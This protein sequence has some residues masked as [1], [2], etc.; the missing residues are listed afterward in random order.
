MF[1]PVCANFWHVSC[2]LMQNW[3]LLQGRS[4]KVVYQYCALVNVFVR[5]SMCLIWV[6]W[7]YS[8]F[9][10][11]KK[12]D[13]V[14]V[15][16]TSLYG[17]KTLQFKRQSCWDGCNWYLVYF[18]VQCEITKASH[19]EYFINNGISLRRWSSLLI[20]QQVLKLPTYV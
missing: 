9:V 8:A 3:C 4:K 10:R 5:F 13:L 16:L 14:L 20:I 2:Y 12:T 17:V 18:A 15:K 7:L 6:G 1:F 19:W 11:E